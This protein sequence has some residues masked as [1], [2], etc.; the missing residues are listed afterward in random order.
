MKT[1]AVIQCNYVG[2]EGTTDISLRKDPEDA[3]DLAISIATTMTP[4]SSEN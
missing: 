4:H 1:I 2:W 3:V